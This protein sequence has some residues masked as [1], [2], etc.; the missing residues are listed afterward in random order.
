MTT[1]DEARLEALLQDAAE[2]LE[3]DADVPERIV[4]SA[5]AGRRRPEANT[6]EA[7]DSAHPVAGRRARLAAVAAVAAALVAVTVASTLAATGGPAPRP[8]AGFGASLSVGSLG[9]KTTGAPEAYRSDVALQPSDNGS[10]L[11]TVVTPAKVVATGVVTLRVPPSHV[12]SALAT[13]TALALR[14]DGYVASSKVHGGGSSGTEHAILVL[15]V[16]EPR[17]S[18]AV[19]AVERVGAVVSAVT[20][21]T[22]VTSAYVDYQARIAAAEASRRQYLAIMAKATSIPD[23]LSIQAQ[24]NQIESLI[25]QLEG[26]RNVLA[27]EAAYGTLTVAL[28]NAAVASH[29]SGIRTAIHDSVA[30][31]VAAVEG[32]IRGIGPAVFALLCLFALVVVG[33][34]GWRTTRRRLL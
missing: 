5:S 33:R 17:F 8:T 13:L 7:S 31:F 3:V 11:S 15:R 32:L 4:A 22:D 23:I 21:S 1:I 9:Q 18:A 24:L 2:A 19:A 16:P 26:A 30:G 10:T 6:P 20:N 27:N 29:E 28:N 25:E 34:V 12:A 14:D